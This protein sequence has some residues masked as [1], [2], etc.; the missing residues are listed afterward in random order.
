MQCNTDS[1]TAFRSLLY[2]W[3]SLRVQTPLHLCS[4]IAVNYKSVLSGVVILS[5]DIAYVQNRVRKI[6]VRHL[7]TSCKGRILNIQGPVGYDQI[8]LQKG[9]NS[10]KCAPVFA[11]QKTVHRHVIP[12]LFIHFK[13]LKQ[14]IVK[15]FVRDDKVC[16]NADHILRERLIKL[17]AERGITHFLQFI[18]KL[19]LSVSLTRCKG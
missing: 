19:D 10:H 15:E 2:P 7:V 5:S 9:G 6:D 14:N 17:G 18:R 4:R 13:S 1:L 16:R 11:H 8:S 3:N 12:A